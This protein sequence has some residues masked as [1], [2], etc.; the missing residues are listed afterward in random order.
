VEPRRGG[1]TATYISSTAI[2]GNLLPIMYTTF[3]QVALV[4]TTNKFY[5][6]YY[7]YQAPPARP[8]FAI[9]G[10][11]LFFRLLSTNNPGLIIRVKTPKLATQDLLARVLL[12]LATF[13]VG[14]RSTAKGNRR[15][16]TNVL[17]RMM[18][19]TVVASAVEY[20]VCI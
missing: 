6:C 7:M 15:L 5:C 1:W 13:L 16:T 19:F 18:M 8:Q 4:L 12:I 9:D 11:F 17:E 10:D 2:H 3:L 14:S 20:P